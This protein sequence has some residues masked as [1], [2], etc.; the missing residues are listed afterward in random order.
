MCWDWKTERVLKLMLER[1]FKV[2]TGSEGSG[3]VEEFVSHPCEVCLWY[4]VFSGTLQLV[5]QSA[6]NGCTDDGVVWKAAYKQCSLLEMYKEPLI[7]NRVMQWSQHWK[8]WY[9]G[10]CGKVL[11]LG[12]HAECRRWSRLGGG[13]KGKMCLKEVQ[14]IVSSLDSQRSIAQTER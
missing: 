3:T 11:L 12:R 14:R 5:A 13:C 7:T 10:K 4:Q 6:A 2:M 9:S 8:R 1:L